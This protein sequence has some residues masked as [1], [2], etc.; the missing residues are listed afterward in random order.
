MEND[1]NSD[2]NGPSA[3]TDPSE[4][5]WTS[6]EAWEALPSRPDL[7]HTFG[8][9]TVEWDVIKHDSGE[10]NLIFLP[11]EQDALADDAFIVAAEDDVCQVC[12]RR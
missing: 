2:V 9:E 1:N 4:G 3:K 5:S 7:E 6:L 10:E 12:E 8:Y 11:A